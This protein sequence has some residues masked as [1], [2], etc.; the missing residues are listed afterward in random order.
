M[1]QAAG[2]D[3]PAVDPPSLGLAA[4]TENFKAA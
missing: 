3:A 4:E 1:I 2:A